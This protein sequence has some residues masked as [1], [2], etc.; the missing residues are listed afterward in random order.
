MTRADKIR[1]V[2]REA[3]RPVSSTEIV[4][5]VPG[6]QTH[7]AIGA[8][9]RQG[10]ID[11]T[12]ERGEYRYWLAREPVI[13]PTFATE[14][15]RKARTKERERIRQAKRRLDRGTP[16]RIRFTSED[17]RR[18]RR[19]ERDR[20]RGEKRRR[21]AG[22]LPF[23]DMIAVRRAEAAAKKAARD[24]ERAKER[25]EREALRIARMNDPAY[26]AERKAAASESNR[27]HQAKRRDAAKKAKAAFLAAE[28][29]KRAK[30]T[31]KINAAFNCAI[32][33][34]K[35]QLE[36]A[37]KRVVVAETVDE[38]MARTGRKPEVLP[39]VQIVPP[40]VGREAA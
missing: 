35:P 11:R 28:A 36:D 19:K 30:A 3:G 33:P 2:L 38:W 29:K 25:A 15:E 8:M 34:A 12:G 7:H 20:V 26:Q 14:E 17:E 6:I 24:A 37:P 16:A 9:Y 21:Q 23:A 1:T 13:R 18:E 22:A 31:A 4:A 27:K 39:G 5:K 32:E 10:H 40:W